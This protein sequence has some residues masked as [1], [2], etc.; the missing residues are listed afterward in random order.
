MGGIGGAGERQQ[1][2]WDRGSSG[3]MGGIGG[4][5]ERGRSWDGGVRWRRVR[6]DAGVV[7]CMGVSGGWRLDGWRQIGL[8]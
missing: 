4:A 8:G 2:R 3:K 1:D 6:H 7:S 5:A